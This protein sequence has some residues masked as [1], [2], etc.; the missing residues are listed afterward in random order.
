MLED[1]KNKGTK[2]KSVDLLVIDTY[3]AFVRNETPA[4]PANFKDLINKVRDMGIA[5]LIVHHANS[6][7]EA[8]GFASKLDLFYLMLN[9][10]R[11]PESPDRDLDEQTRIIT[12]ENPRDSMS[13]QLREPFKILFDN[14]S[15]HWKGVD[16]RNENAELKLI[17][18]GYKKQG[19][20]RNAICQM[21]GL[22]KSALS[23]RLK[24]AE[25]IK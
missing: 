19:F 18:E 14:K 21:L 11:D 10:S 24:K 16:L 23:D 20:D 4:T 25:E 8:R 5:V 13:S 9:L 2:G 15:K 17:V 1:A 12:Y 3:T 6:A 22:E 7:N